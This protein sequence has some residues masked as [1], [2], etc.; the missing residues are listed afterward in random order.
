MKEC[1]MKN[2]IKLLGIALAVFL[3]FGLA[4]CVDPEGDDLGAIFIDVPNGTE[5]QGTLS[6]PFPLGTVLTA[7]YNGTEKEEDVAFQWKKG[8]SEYQA[9]AGETNATYTANTE[10]WYLVTVTIGDKSKDSAAVYVAD[11]VTTPDAKEDFYSSWKAGNLGSGQSARDEYVAIIK[12]SGG[13]SDTFELF[14]SDVG[15]TSSS[16]ATAWHYAYLSFD[17]TSWEKVTEPL[18]D[19]P[20]STLASF[21]TG[22]KL[23]GTMKHADSA[24]G[25]QANPVPA[26]NSAVVYYVYIKSDKTQLIRTSWNPAN[27]KA[28]QSEAGGST[29]FYAKVTP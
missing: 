6:E 4:A 9:I 7:V 14:F 28:I 5:G 29:R 22:Y 17:I 23:S 18:T 24:M 3:T 2:L 16:A 10:G 13:A 26:V 11:T 12:G 27:G 8:G 15:A 25:T 20:A 1:F 21:T 19:Q